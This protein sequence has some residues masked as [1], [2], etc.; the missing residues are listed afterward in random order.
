MFDIVDRVYGDMEAAMKGGATGNPEGEEGEAGAGGG[1]GGG[2]LGGSFGGGGGG[3]EDLDF[4]D[5]ETE[6]EESAAATE[7]GGEEGAAEE[8]GTD[9]EQAETAQ[10]NEVFTKRFEKLLKE[11]KAKLKK[12]LDNR[13]KKYKKIYFD[14]LI[15]SIKSDLNESKTPTK[16]TDKSIKVNDDINSIIK[17]ID[18]ML[19]K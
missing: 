12:D 19:D 1:G 5:E 16:I 9:V 13:Q 10:V 18:G 3:G 14:K 15:G 11:E 7:A 4:G 6:G 17:G 2:G 8:I